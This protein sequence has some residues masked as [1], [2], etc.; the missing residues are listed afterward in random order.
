MNDTRETEHDEE[1]LGRVRQLIV[2]ELDVKLTVEEVS[3]QTKLFAGGLELDSF[4]IV[5]LINLLE[6]AFDFE[7][8]PED[9]APER[10]TDLRTLTLTVQRNLDPAG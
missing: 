5:E 7:F 8:S 3:A 6:D 2:D 9:L 1:V 4:A 10:F